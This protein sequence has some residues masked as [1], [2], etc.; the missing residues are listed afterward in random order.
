MTDSPPFGFHDAFG[1]TIASQV[2]LP[3]LRPAAAGS[4]PDLRI[5]R[6]S[7]G[8]PLP[9]RERGVVMDYAAEGGVVMAWPD[10]AGFRFVDRGTIV[11]EPY[12]DTPEAYLAF[13]IL[14]PVMAW[15]LNWRGRF[16]LHASAVDIGGRIVALLGDKMA[17]KSTTA[18]AFLRAGHR[19][20]TDDLL[21]LS[22]DE[23][24]RARAFPAFAQV[25]LAD[26]AAA[27]VRVD[28]AEPLPLVMEG[29]PKRQ[30]RLSAMRESPGEV[31][32]VA[33]LMRGGPEPAFVPLDTAGAVHALD[34]FSYLPRFGDA[35]FSKADRARHFRNCVGLAD[36]ATVGT[37][38]IPDSLDRLGE[39][40][41]AV[42]RVVAGTAA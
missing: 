20:M 15:L 34:R 21:A 38:H 37:L 7:I 27:T 2:P 30:H 11:V 41:D 9:S 23:G 32:L 6:G 42:E 4:D 17:G 25:K 16:V 24:D 18:A 5:E 29:F 35:P 1:M 19:L 13:P 8:Y 10:V 40:V 28:N 36:A 3:E 39:T 26:D 12:P 31:A 33:V 14:G 22:T